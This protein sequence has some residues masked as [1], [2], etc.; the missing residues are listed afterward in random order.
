VTL[1]RFYR[2]V[3]LFGPDCV[4]DTARLS[5][6]PS[7]LLKLTN[8][9][10]DLIS[11]ACKPRKA[12]EPKDVTSYR[13]R[14]AEA[15]SKGKQGLWL[16]RMAVKPANGEADPRVRLCLELHSKGEK[17][18]IIASRTGRSAAWVYK[19]VRDSVSGPKQPA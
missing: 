12:G 11:R 6:Q 16:E 15:R 9:V 4:Y 13:A 3:V 2:H 18:T 7:D 10:N 17:P 5:L 19:T 14:I 8:R 1:D